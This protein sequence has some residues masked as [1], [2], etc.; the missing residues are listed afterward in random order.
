MAEVIDSSMLPN[1]L[2][3]EDLQKGKMQFAYSHNDLFE[4]LAAN[5]L[6]LIS[7]SC[8]TNISR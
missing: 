4:S 6:D 2:R 8:S 5:Y 3:E 1:W 7:S